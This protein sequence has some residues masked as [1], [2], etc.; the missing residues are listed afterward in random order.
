[1][2]LF[3]ILYQIWIYEFQNMEALGYSRL[4]V[5]SLLPHLLFFTKN[6]QNPFNKK[7]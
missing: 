5:S 2:T 6:Y 4:M 3:Y 7:K 1:M